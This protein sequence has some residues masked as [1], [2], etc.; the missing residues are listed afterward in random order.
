MACWPDPEAPLAC[1][2][3][4]GASHAPDVP[5]VVHWHPPYP[6][7]PPPTLKTRALEKLSM[8][9]LILEGKERRQACGFKVLDAKQW[10]PN[11]NLNES[12]CDQ[13]DNAKDYQ[14]ISPN[15]WPGY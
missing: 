5:R 10:P 3:G 9:G 8:A 14:G 12:E 13:N 1:L 4:R 15:Q 11:Q 2:A 6:L 7:P